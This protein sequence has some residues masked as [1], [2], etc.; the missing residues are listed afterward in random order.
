MCGSVKSLVC[1]GSKYEQ[2]TLYGIP[3]ELIKIIIKI[4]ILGTRGAAQ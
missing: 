3:K 1:G 2:N 4:G